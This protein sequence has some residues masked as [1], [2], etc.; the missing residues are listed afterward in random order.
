MVGVHEV[1][2]RLRMIEA[3]RQGIQLAST[4]F[5]IKYSYELLRV[6]MIFFLNCFLGEREDIWVYSFSQVGGL[7][8]FSG[9]HRQGVRHLR[10]ALSLL[11]PSL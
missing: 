10:A 11:Q 2:G 9:V 3:Q 1:Y 7:V 8:S 4:K 5:S 6:Q